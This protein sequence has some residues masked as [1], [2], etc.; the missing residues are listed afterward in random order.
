MH[1]LFIGP[2][3]AHSMTRNEMYLCDMH[4]RVEIE[5]VF[6]FLRKKRKDGKHSVLEE[7]KYKDV[8]TIEGYSFVQLLIVHC[9][10]N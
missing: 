4:T 7:Q 3:T 5:G 9:I 6:F 8:P 10:W 1:K 2:G